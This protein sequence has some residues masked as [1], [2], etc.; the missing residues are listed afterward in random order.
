ML[1]PAPPPGEVAVQLNLATP[2]E[3]ATA[4]VSV[5]V[6]AYGPVKV[7]WEMSVPLEAVGAPPRNVRRPA[8][9]ASQRCEV[10]V[11]AVP[12][13]WPGQGCA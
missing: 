3:P 9:L 1:V 11:C 13:A 5:Y 7:P 6:F 8:A 2:T 10:P 4:I 12:D